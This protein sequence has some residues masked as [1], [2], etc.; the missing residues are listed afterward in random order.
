MWWQWVL[1]C[2]VRLLGCVGS[3]T[4]SCKIAT[5]IGAQVCIRWRPRKT[6]SASS[7]C[8]MYCLRLNSLAR[9]P[10]LRRCHT[11]CLL[12]EWQPSPTQEVSAHAANRHRRSLIPNTSTALSGRLP[13]PLCFRSRTP[14]SCQCC[15]SHS[16]LCHAMGGKIF[17]LH[18]PNSG[19]RPPHL[20]DWPG[21][22]KLTRR[23]LI[24]GTPGS[25]A[26]DPCSD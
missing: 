25:A 10:W 5:M 24:G 2:S 21:R 18:L 23:I 1:P 15:S 12:W 9:A 14:C 4:I 17:G 19:P 22:S 11:L 20:N 8:R 13:L 16:R 6:H 3:S 7:Q 26:W